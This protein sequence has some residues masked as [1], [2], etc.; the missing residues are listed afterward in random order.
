MFKILTAIKI[1]KKII[2]LISIA[3]ITF[4][5]NIQAQHAKPGDYIKNPRIKKFEGTWKA[6]DRDIGLT[7]VFNSNERVFEKIVN[8]YTDYIEGTVSFSE[9]GKR[10]VDG[11]KIIVNGTSLPDE[12]YMLHAYLNE[13]TRGG[14]VLVS[15][16]NPKDLD[17]ILIVYSRGNSKKD[18]SGRLPREVILK[19]VK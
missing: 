6:T 5:C 1:M 3:I 16:P 18:I 13:Q 9:S 17:T 4:A 14:N 8:I 10:V 19:R 12:P 2:F 11:K 15:F 7:I